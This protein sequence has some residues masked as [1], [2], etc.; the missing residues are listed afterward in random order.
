MSEA[1][2]IAEDATF[3]IACAM[4]HIGWLRGVLGVLRDRLSV[5]AADSAYATTADL[6]IYNADDWHNQLDCERESLEERIALTFCVDA[7]APQNGF[8]SNRGANAEKTQ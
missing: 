8:L 6:A 1:E 4:D 3:Q 5:S 7:P 2:R